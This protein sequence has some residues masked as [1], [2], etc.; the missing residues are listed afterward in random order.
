METPQQPTGQGQLGGDPRLQ[1]APDYGTPGPHV[2]DAA[3]NGTPPSANPARTGPLIAIAAGAFLAVLV[4][5][6]GSAR[7]AR[8]LLAD[9]FSSH[10]KTG[11][12]S[13]AGSAR[14][15]AQSNRQR[16]QKEAE[17]L[18]EQAVA[19]SDGAVDQIS[20]RV[21]SWRG[22]LKWNSQIATLSTAA[23]NSSNF[24]VRES[25]I[26]VELAAYGLAKTSS[27]V[28][29]LER[30]AESPDHAHKIWAL[31]ALG[32]IANRGIETE[33]VVQILTSYLHDP[34]EDS[35]RWAVEGLA[36]VGT[37]STILPLLRTM[38]DDPSPLVRERAACSLAESGMLTHEQRLS[39]IPE[40]L[41]YTDDPS[42]DAQT[43][44][45][46]FQALG[47][48]TGQRLPSDT[49]AWRSWY[50]KTV[51]SN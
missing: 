17:A 34:D 11:L 41:N 9:F 13:T 35:R 30:D 19:N 18:L 24:R 12:H 43:R 20:E 47:D 46:A 38:R 5:G 8:L 14:D 48:I 3:A 44:A 15:A 23:L 26:E 33:R 4:G 51:A 32:A 36:L 28:D 25:G 1:P 39:A 27:S 31:W 40:L 10:G 45:W 42:L 6:I 16:P 37:N 49:A 2:Q 7:A 50:G 29:L 21:D 22:K